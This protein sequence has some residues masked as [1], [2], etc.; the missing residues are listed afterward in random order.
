[1]IFKFFFRRWSG[2]ALSAFL[3]LL[4][5]GCTATHLVMQEQ[6]LEEAGSI[7]SWSVYSISPGRVERPSQYQYSYVITPKL[8][9]DH[10]Q[11]AL[12]ARGAAESYTQHQVQLIYHFDI[13]Q[14]NRPYA[15]LFE[16]H[17]PISFSAPDGR[18]NRTYELGKLTL[19]LRDQDGKQVLWR[20]EL[21]DLLSKGK[22]GISDR[23][24]EASIKLVMQLPNFRP[25]R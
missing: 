11:G 7:P 4:W 5:P 16:A 20:G 21:I 23:L 14:T 2:P 8:I 18:I 17:Y 25:V 12:H 24:K 6:Y 10:L 1:M 3:L 22:D 15:E 9:Q 19:E 13:V